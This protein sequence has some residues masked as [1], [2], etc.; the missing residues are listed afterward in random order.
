MHDG[1]YHS[2]RRGR[3]WAF[4]Y[5]GRLKWRCGARQDWHDWHDWMSESGVCALNSGGGQKKIHN[6]KSF[7]PNNRGSSQFRHRYI[8]WL[9][10]FRPRPNDK[11]LR[12]Q[13]ALESRFC[14]NRCL[15]VFSAFNFLTQTQAKRKAR[16]LQSRSQISVPR[17][18][19]YCLTYSWEE[20][21][22]A[23]DFHTDS[24]TLLAMVILISRPS[25]R[26]SF[27]ATRA[28]KSN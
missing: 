4:G 20:K 16:S 13:F 24:T 18:F 12:H 26:P 21:T 27:L 9:L 14:R 19:R 11:R 17:T 1:R 7:F 5:S 8:P 15:R 22:P 28:P 6:L 2:S 3:R 10:Y 25:S 23:N